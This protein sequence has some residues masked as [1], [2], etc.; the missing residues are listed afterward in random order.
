MRSIDQALM[1][2]RGA[3][4]RARARLPGAL[5]RPVR[6]A[7]LDLRVA[8]WSGLDA[9]ADD[10]ALRPAQ[11]RE[12]IV[13][14]VAWLGPLPVAVWPGTQA[15]DAAWETARGALRLAY[16]LDCHTTLVTDGHGLDAD[17][18]RALVDGGL[19][20][21][22]LQL[23]DTADA[24][25]AEAALGALA[26]AATARGVPLRLEAALLW[27]AALAP[28]AA[29]LATGLSRAGATAV[30]V[31][32]GWR[33]TGPALPLPPGLAVAPAAAQLT[34]ALAGAR[35]DGAPGLP[36]SGRC[37]VAHRRVERSPDG[38][39]RAC[40]HLPPL[41]DAALR[42]A[43]TTGRDHRDRIQACDRQCLHPLLG[44]APG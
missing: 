29:T 18:A 7:R 35:G 15:A 36:G 1:Q 13:D 28:H 14:A 32:P 27:S 16:R 21:V 31:V 24:P 38:L 20:R 41:P 39:L 4:R 44:G 43:W 40:P 6:P 17:R 5:G 8:R 3:T 30:A 12:T 37:S 23:A 10:R 33:D 22:Q 34:G 11:A 26:A 19:H 9:D 42:E 2:L 25:A